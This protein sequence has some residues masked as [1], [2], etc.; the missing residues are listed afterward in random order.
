MLK[1]KKALNMAKLLEN[2]MA[3]QSIVATEN[4]KHLVNLLVYKIIETKGKQAQRQ[5]TKD[6]FKN[7]WKDLLEGLLP[8][9]PLL[10]STAVVA[11]KKVFQ[12]KVSFGST[13]PAKRTKD[14]N[15]IPRNGLPSNYY[16][17]SARLPI[18]IAAAPHPLD[19]ASTPE[20]EEAMAKVTPSP[21]ED[22]VV[23]GV[24]TI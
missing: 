22:D 14:K 13:Q 11:S 9:R 7:A 10:A 12:R 23:T 20:G 24:M 15:K 4:M 2:S 5:F 21:M 18:H 17:N 1:M 19:R 8:S 16:A 6:A 3:V